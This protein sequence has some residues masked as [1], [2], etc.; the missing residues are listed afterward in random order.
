MDNAWL[1]KLNAY[2]VSKGK[3]PKTLNQNFVKANASNVKKLSEQKKSRIPNAESVFPTVE[4]IKTT[5]FA[6]NVD[7]RTPLTSRENNIF[8]T[9]KNVSKKQNTAK[10]FHHGS[11]KNA[12]KCDTPKK[13]FNCQ[14]PK[15]SFAVAAKKKL[16]RRSMLSC[17][18]TAQINAIQSKS[19]K[20]PTKSLLLKHACTPKNKLSKRPIKACSEKVFRKKS[21]SLKQKSRTPRYKRS[22]AENEKEQR[23]DQLRAWM[24]AKGKDPKALRGFKPAK[25]LQTPV[26]SPAKED[27]ASNQVTQWPSLRE[28][29][30]CDELSVLVNQT[31][32]EAQACMEKECTLANVHKHLLEFREKVPI[33]EKHASFWLTLAL[34]YQKLHKSEND[35]ISIFEKAIALEAMP[36]EE[37]KKAMKK[38]VETLVDKPDV[39]VLCI[40]SPNANIDNVLT[41][42]ASSNTAL[43]SFEAHLTPQPL[44]VPLVPLSPLVTAETPSSIIKLRMIPR[45]SPNFRKLIAKKALP[46]SITGIVTPVRRSK[47]IENFKRNYPK[48][49]IDQ[50]TCF[51]SALDLVNAGENSENSSKDYI[52][53]PNKA[54]GDDYSDISKVLQF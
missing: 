22:A 49:L 26:N 17:H 4:K 52:F 54:L 1:E 53:D 40:D 44:T 8:L 34:L 27:S 10:K 7:I 48:G 43:G 32:K 5:K 15:S 13:V 46:T 21:I 29:D 19:A 28:E 9:D 51:A 14:P 36:V 42:A 31:M 18:N 35:I 50:D 2:L 30:F 24:I 11:Q 33:A 41:T 23:L 37:V 45:S 3:P 20:T 16:V 12:P 39:P 38:F 6:P 25:V 47:R